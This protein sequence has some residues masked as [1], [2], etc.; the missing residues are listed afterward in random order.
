V[1]VADAS[2]LIALAKMRRLN[3]LK[4]VYGDTILG[5]A[6][7]TEVVD[8]GRE[9]G[10]PGVEQVEKAL[11]AGWLRVVR[12]SVKE[13]RIMQ[14]ILRATRLDEGE[15]E[16]L[17]LAQSRNATLIVDDKDGRGMAATLGVA[18]Q[19]TAGVLLEAFLKGR[20]S[21]EELEDTVQDLNRVMW[22]SPAVVAE[23]LSRAREAKR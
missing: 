4:D 6:V 3:L 22:L 12:L 11:E 2:V 7:K 13:Q 15:A 20:L 21:F 14:G 17:A 10:A 16:S 18:Y 1:I 8:Q 5:P 9:I 23:I 19:G